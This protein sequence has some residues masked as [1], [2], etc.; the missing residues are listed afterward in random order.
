MLFGLIGE[1]CGIPEQALSV[2]AELRADNQCIAGK[3]V[4]RTRKRVG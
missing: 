3:V 2:G 4:H 1:L